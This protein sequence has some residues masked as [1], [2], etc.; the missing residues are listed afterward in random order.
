[1]ISTVDPAKRRRGASALLAALLV[2]AA[3]VAG[4]DAAGGSE[5]APGN[6]SEASEAPG[7]PSEPSDSDG[8]LAPFLPATASYNGPADFVSSWAVTRNPDGTIRVKDTVGDFDTVYTLKTEDGCL[9]QVSVLGGSGEPQDAEATWFCLPPAPFANEYAL[10]GATVKESA[11]ERWVDDPNLG[12]VLEVRI[13]RTTGTET[14]TIVEHWAAGLGLV[15]R[16]TTDTK[17]KVTERRDIIFAG[18]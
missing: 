8:L 16:I 10:N 1:M 18:S 4:C 12:Q 17:G 5:T 14:S 13:E 2:A 6:P 11:T 7:G 3:L 9:K 15:S